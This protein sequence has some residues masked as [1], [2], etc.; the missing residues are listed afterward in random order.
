MGGISDETYG[1]K[2]HDFEDPDG[3][4]EIENDGDR[5]NQHERVQ[6]SLPPAV[7]A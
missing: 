5:K 4:S 1:T 6:A 3:E 2:S 7:H